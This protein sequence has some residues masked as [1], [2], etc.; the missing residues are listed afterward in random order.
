MKRSLHISVVPKFKAGDLPPRGYLEW[1]EWSRVQQAAGVKQQPCSQ[2][3][4]W[5]TPQ[6]VK[7]HI[8]PIMTTIPFTAQRDI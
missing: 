2:C 6:E 5:L 8:C 7:I 4:R 1:M 3:G